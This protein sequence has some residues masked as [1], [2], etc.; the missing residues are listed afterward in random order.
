[1]R[2]QVFIRLV[3]YTVLAALSMMIP[4]IPTGQAQTPSPAALRRRLR[5]KCPLRLYL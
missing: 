5:L 3:T 2:E 4:A 1:M